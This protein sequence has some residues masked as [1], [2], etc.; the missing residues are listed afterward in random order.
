VICGDYGGSNDDG[1]ECAV[2]EIL[3][4]SH[5][6]SRNFWVWQ[7]REPKTWPRLNWTDLQ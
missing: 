5:E 4:Y 6:V 1:L 2:R 3:P 7:N